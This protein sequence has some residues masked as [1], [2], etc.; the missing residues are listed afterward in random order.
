MK[1]LIVI[2]LLSCGPLLGSTVTKVKG[3]KAIIETEYEF[4]RG[5]IVKTSVNGAEV[6]FKVYKIMKSKIFVKILKGELVEGDKIDFLEEESGSD[7]VESGDDSIKEKGFYLNPI[8]SLG[9]ISETELA[10]LSNMPILFGIQVGYFI[11]KFS[12]GFDYET[13]LSDL[14]YKDKSD[15]SDLGSAS[16]SIL[17]IFFNYD[18]T[19]KFLIH[20]GYA[21]S[22][23]SKDAEDR[24]AIES[25]N[26]LKLG[27]FYKITNKVSI[28]LNYR[29]YTFGKYTDYINP[30]LS[31]NENSDISL[32]TVG[33]NFP[34]VF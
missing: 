2:F 4:S 1:L 32:L 5:E 18:V 16:W 21:F 22:G 27:V 19:E 24:F 13:S 29:D 33:M 34:F 23:K 12:F 10:S 8:V 26:G 31:D 7:Y 30:S 9:I 15:G 20:G 11:S 28:N 6:K 3:K 17:G 25:P 14:S